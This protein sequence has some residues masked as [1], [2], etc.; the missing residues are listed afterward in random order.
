M[1]GIH[2]VQYSNIQCNSRK[3]KWY[4]VSMYEW[5][6]WIQLQTRESSVCK[7]VLWQRVCSEPGASI[8]CVPV[9]S[10][11]S[12]MKRGLVHIKSVLVQS[13]LFD[14]YIHVAV[15]AKSGVVLVTIIDHSSK[16]RGCVPELNVHNKIILCFYSVTLI[17]PAYI[18]DSLTLPNSPL[19]AAL[20]PLFFPTNRN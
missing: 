19:F 17:Y 7:H 11:I 10:K 18:I 16:L 2:N 13:K 15:G 8:R 5:V 20:V 1:H 12:A 9:A 3:E 14:A 4:G 6:V